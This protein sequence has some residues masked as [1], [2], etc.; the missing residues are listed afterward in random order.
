VVIVVAVGDGGSGCDGV[1]VV[2]ADGGGCDVV[3]VAVGVVVVVM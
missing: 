1:V 2:V 3:V